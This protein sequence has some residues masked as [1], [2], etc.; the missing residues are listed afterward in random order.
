MRSVR[1]GRN[2]FARVCEGY[3]IDGDL[4]ERKLAEARR[5]ESL[6]VPGSGLWGAEREEGWRRVVSAVGEWFGKVLGG[7][8][9]R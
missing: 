8:E 2:G 3:G 7:G 4:E 1:E 9:K 6:L 5:V